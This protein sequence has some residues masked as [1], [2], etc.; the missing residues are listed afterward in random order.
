MEIEVTIRINSKYSV[1]IKSVLPDH[2]KYIKCEEKD[3][4]V[5]CSVHGTEKDVRKTINEF[6]ESIE[7]VE[8]ISSVKT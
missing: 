7:F 8:K 6:L 4:V 1:I 3:D 2:L 5:I